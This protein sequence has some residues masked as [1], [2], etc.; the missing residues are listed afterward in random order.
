[1]L[2]AYDTSETICNLPR[3]GTIPTRSRVAAKRYLLS[4]GGSRLRQ[5]GESAPRLERTGAFDSSAP[6]QTLYLLSTAAMEPR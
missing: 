2:S 6:Y 1:M 5:D 3:R 4:E